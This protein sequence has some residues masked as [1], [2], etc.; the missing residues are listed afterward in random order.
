MSCGTFPHLCLSPH[1]AI[2]FF[3]F[4]I[5]FLVSFSLYPFWFIC[6][7]WFSPL[8]CGLPE[9]R[10]LICSLLFV[11]CLEWCPA[12]SRHSGNIAEQI[13]APSPPISPCR[14]RFY[15]ATHCASSTAVRALP[16][17]CLQK[18]PE[19]CWTRW[20]YVNIK[21]SMEDME[22]PFSEILEKSNISVVIQSY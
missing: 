6:E 16:S 12:H 17:V 9:V 7:L 1:F 21:N 22:A 4:S 14:I 15:V 5:V 8:E 2:V 19:E 10:D 20:T 13:A 11:Q 18:L 3:F